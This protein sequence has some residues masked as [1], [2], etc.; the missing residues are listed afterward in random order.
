MQCCRSSPDR[1]QPQ[2]RIDLTGIGSPTLDLSWMSQISPDLLR[3]HGLDHY[4]GQ[5]G[6]LSHSITSLSMPS[7]R[8]E[9][10][11]SRRQYIQETLVAK[12]S[13]VQYVEPTLQ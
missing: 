5:Q 10:I 13:T 1:Q 12:V 2:E 6:S 3:H 11:A 7:S 4:F 8:E 9:Q